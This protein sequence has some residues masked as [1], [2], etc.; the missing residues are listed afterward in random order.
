MKLYV[1]KYILN[2]IT[3]YFSNNNKTKVTKIKQINLEL[4]DCQSVRFLWIDNPHEPY[5]L[6]I[7]KNLTNCKSVS[8]IKL[9]NYQ[10]IS[11]IE[12][13]D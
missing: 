1:F 12:L 8:S 4:M 5:R 13:M 11:F 6:S 2:N 7:H 9:M 10:F 3:N